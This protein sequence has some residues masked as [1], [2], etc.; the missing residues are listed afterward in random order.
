M[1]SGELTGPGLTPFAFS[2]ESHSGY[3]GAM[4]FQIA[5]DGGV[6]TLQEARTTDRENGEV[7]PYGEKRPTPQDVKLVG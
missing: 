4:V 1:S 7:K 5:A 6:K 3:T 2:K